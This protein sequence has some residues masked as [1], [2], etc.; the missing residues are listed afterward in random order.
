MRFRTIVLGALVLAAVSELTG[1]AAAQFYPNRPITM[2]VP[3]AAGG[4]T[5]TVARIIADRMARSLPQPVVVEDLPGAGGTIAA[6]RVARADPDGYTLSIGSWSSYVVSPVVYPQLPYDVLRDFAPV[7]LLTRTPLLIIAKKDMPAN[8]LQGMVAWL[9]ANPDTAFQGIAGGTDQVA[10][11]LLQ[12]QTGTRFGSVPYRG[13][14]PAMQDLLAGRIDFLFDQPSDALPQIRSGAVK[15][16]AV[17]AGTRLAIAPDIPTVDEAGLPGLYITPW[18]SLWVPA[19]TPLDVIARLNAAAVD[20]LGDPALRKRLADVGQDV[21]PR[22]QQTPEALSVY[23]KAET[24]KWW[25][26][27]KAAGIKAD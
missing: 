7:A 21:I 4:P 18:H 27:I 26:I 13:L 9:K 16:F 19:N 10:G 17:T 14:A 6:A 25:P 15:V 3:Y 20:A 12:Q 8:D 1:G 2:V 23:Y 5:D 22:E 11:F 24:D